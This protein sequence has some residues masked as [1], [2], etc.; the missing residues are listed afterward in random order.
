MA[1][2]T[3]YSTGCPMCTVLEKKMKAKKIAYEVCSDTTEMTKMGFNR[4][5]GLKVGDAVFY[6]EDA[7]KYINNL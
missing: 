5:P 4:V 1:K 7:V 3:L 6:F 2:I